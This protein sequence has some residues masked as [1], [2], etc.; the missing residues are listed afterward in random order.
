MKGQVEVFVEPVKLGGSD[1]TTKGTR[2]EK[3]K[4]DEL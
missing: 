3:G 2:E 1:N 4:V